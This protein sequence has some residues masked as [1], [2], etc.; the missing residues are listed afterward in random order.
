MGVWRRNFGAKKVFLREKEKSRSKEKKFKMSSNRAP[1][2]SA[3]GVIAPPSSARSRVASKVGGGGGVR[4]GLAAPG[5]VVR[6][7]SKDDGQEERGLGFGSAVRHALVQEVTREKTTRQKLV[8]RM[9]SRITEFVQGR[10][11]Q[12]LEQVRKLCQQRHVVTFLGREELRLGQ[13]STA[14][15]GDSIAG[16]LSDLTLVQV[17]KM[18]FSSAEES[19]LS[20]FKIEIEERVSRRLEAEVTLELLS[21]TSRDANSGEVTSYYQVFVAV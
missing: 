17:G 16:Q 8:R 6:S 1:L 9:I 5:T 12:V 20:E 10:R 18:S 21:E 15:K 3:F 11:E 7:T 19:V 4:T 14:S 2:K 13:R